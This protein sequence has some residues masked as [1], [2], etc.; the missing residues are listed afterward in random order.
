MSKYDEIIGFVPR[1][2]L[3]KRALLAHGFSPTTSL[4]NL[5]ERA[6][7][8]EHLAFAKRG[9]LEEDPSRKQLIPY[10]VVTR[11][12]K[13]FTMRRK[14]ASL[15]ARL[16][17][18]GSIGVGGHLSR[19]DEV[20]SAA[21]FDEITAGMMRELHEELAL[22]QAPTIE[23]LT[24]RGLINDD[25]NEVGQVHLGLVYHLALSP[26]AH[27]EVREVEKLEGGWSSLEEL[28]RE[29]TNLE[30]WSAL[31]LAPLANWLQSSL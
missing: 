1:D 21:G 23:Q 5:D 27:V 7:L 22:S 2:M 25:T 31:L 6:L 29:Q 19:V 9:P 10:V 30:T 4:P 20:N 14:R 12:D 24:Y 26:T 18:K 11:G 8:L 3:E 15:E 17:D 28:E 16:H 13:I